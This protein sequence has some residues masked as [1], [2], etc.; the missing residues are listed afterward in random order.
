MGLHEEPP[1]A[2]DTTEKVDEEVPDEVE[3]QD[4]EDI[5]FDEDGNFSKSCDLPFTQNY[6]SF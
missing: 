2:D 5:D 6:F 4:E 3:E 1:K